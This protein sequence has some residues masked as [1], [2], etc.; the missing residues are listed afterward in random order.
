MTSVTAL[1][2]CSGSTDEKAGADTSASAST[3]PKGAVTRAQ[4][5]KIVDTYVTVNNKANKAQNEKLL[6]TVEGGQVHEQSKADYKTFST[7]TKA[8]Q[9]DYEKPFSYQSREYY[10]PAD[11]DWFAVKATA[12]GSKDPALL[13]FDK[14]GGAWKLMSAVYTDDAPLPKIATD[15]NG[16][17]TAVD[18]ATRVGSMAPNDVSAAFEDFF[19]TG[20]KKAGA[21]LSRTTQAA[22]DS[23]KLYNDR[24]K[25]KISRWSTKKYFAKPPAHKDTYALRLADG[26]VLA[27]IPT[28]HTQETLLKP[29]YMSSFQLTP[30]EE[31]SV[32]NPEKRALVTDTFQ[33]MALA[34]LPKSGKPAVI[35]RE[36][37]MTDSK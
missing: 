12:S 24:D 15:D 18:P 23:L 31:E 13:V 27:V 19:E 3:A 16:L 17:A 26:G 11:E 20:G 21:T 28:A 25:G 4:A 22:K 32:Y 2:A 29:Q 5:A 8:D 34:T 30:S 10:I 35:A 1:T 9:S 37:G 7:W 33:G 14:E 36:Y 6:A